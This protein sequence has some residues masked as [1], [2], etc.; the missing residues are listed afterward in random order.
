MSEWLNKDNL[1]YY[2]E[3]GFLCFDVITFISLFFIPAFY[4]RLYS[5]N[6]TLLTLSNR[7]GWILEEIPT[8]VVTLYYTYFNIIN[9]F[10][11]YKVF[12]MS[13]FFIHY[14][15]R[16]L[17]F[18]F[19]LVNSKKMPIEIVI[20]GMVFN[21]LNS[22]MINRSIFMFTDYSNYSFIRLIVGLIVF[23]SGMYINIIHD[24]LVIKLKNKSD[25]YI[26][27]YGYLFEYIS[28][29]NYLGE[30]IEWTGFAI[31]SNS[32]AGIIF[33]ISTF[34][35]LFPRALEYKKWYHNKFGD[36]YPKNRKA[37]IPYLI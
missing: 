31:V 18:P 37:I 19:K 35:N 32:F 20:M 21:I 9:N 4:G 22:I 1:N 28:S 11:P 17:I 27:P 3:Y 24:Y 7:L 30:I 13:L 2:L 29:P 25:G 34:S 16:T 10:N 8:L 14:I 26:I 15:H 12:I 6:K 36:S 5:S 23:F 33:A